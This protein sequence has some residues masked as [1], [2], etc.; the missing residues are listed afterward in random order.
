MR[1]RWVMDTEAVYKQAIEL[2]GKGKHPNALAIYAELI[3]SKEDP[4]F[5]IAY[6]EIPGSGLEL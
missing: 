2:E 5:F 4:R 1:K 6:V 3:K